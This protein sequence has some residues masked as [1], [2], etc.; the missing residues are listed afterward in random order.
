MV[1]MDD[2]EQEDGS[3]SKLGQVMDRFLLHD[4]DI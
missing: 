4:L 3:R 1:A 2:A